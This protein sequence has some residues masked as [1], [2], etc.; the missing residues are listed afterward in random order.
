MFSS[1]RFSAM[2][3]SSLVVASVTVP[4]FKFWTAYVLREWK[5]SASWSN[6]AESLPPVTRWP[7]HEGVG[8]SIVAAKSPH[9]TSGSTD[10][11]IFRRFSTSIRT[12][13]LVTGIRSNLY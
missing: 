10:T 5:M 11:R 9:T 4:F 1:S 13:F 6:S 2:G 7:Q 3:R 12:P 8:R